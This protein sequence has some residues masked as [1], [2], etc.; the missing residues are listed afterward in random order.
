[1][2]ITVWHLPDS[3]TMRSINEYQD[4]VDECGVDGPSRKGKHGGTNC[5]DRQERDLWG[6]KAAP[7]RDPVL[8]EGRS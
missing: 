6:K 2:K 7:H 8:P 4:V 3:D 1:M 5:R